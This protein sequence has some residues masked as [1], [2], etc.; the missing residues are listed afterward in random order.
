MKVH[1]PMVIAF[2][3]LNKIFTGAYYEIRRQTINIGKRMTTQ[4]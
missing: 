3:W 1:F 2:Q 4:F